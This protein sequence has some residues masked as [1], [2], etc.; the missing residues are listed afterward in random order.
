MQKS[1]ATRE[2][3]REAGVTIQEVDCLLDARLFLVEYPRWDIKGPDQ[4]IILHSMFLHA[5]GE[6]QKEAE[7]FICWGW[8]QTLPWL[9]P[10]ATLAAIQLVGYQTS[11]KEILDL[12]HEEYLLRR[13]L[14]LLT[15]RPWLRE[16]AIQDI[17]SSLM[18][19]LQRWGAPLCW[20]RINVGQPPLPISQPAIQKPSPGPA[21]EEAHMMRNS[22]RPGKLTSILELD[23]ERLSLEGENI[24]HWHSAASVAATWRV[25][26]LIGV[27]GLQAN[28]GQRGMWPSVIQR[29]SWF[30]VRVP[31]G[32]PKGT[33]PRHEW[34]GEGRTLYPPKCQR[35]Y[36][37][38]EWPWLMQQWN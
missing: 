17:L 16:E 35:C 38:E 3:P 12:Y 5:T 19:H 10:E 13:P 24:V 20:R 23:I 27:R 8:W 30:W 1:Q 32:H 21:R 22:R 14:G 25:N 18:S 33:W 6:G 7:R 31:T 9:D 37:L 34:R 36:V 15:C 26:P 2:W 4:P 11:W 28:A 29:L